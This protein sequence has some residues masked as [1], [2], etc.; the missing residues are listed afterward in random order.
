M[1]PKQNIYVNFP[2]PSTL[3]EFLKL[4]NG[5]VTEGMCKGARTYKNKECTVVQ[6]YHGAKRSFQ[7]TMDCA[8]KYFPEAT[9]EEIFKTLITLNHPDKS[10]RQ[11][12]IRPTY[13]STIKKPVYMF[14][15]RINILWLD[16]YT[17]E[18]GETSWKE[19]FKKYMNISSTTELYTYID[20]LRN[21]TATADDKK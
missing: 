17:G 19:L 9:E 10:G 7:E 20:G 2:I 16:D 4:F 1:T 18:N 14:Y 5:Y 6:S 11:T 21:P 13:C 3:E 15:Y 8:Q 12:Y